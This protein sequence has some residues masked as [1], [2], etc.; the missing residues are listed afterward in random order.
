[1]WEIFIDNRLYPT[2]I[3]EFLAAATGIL[4]LLKSKALGKDDKLLVYYLIFIFV[5]D[6]LAITYGLYGYVYNWKHLDFISEQFR[7]IYWIYNILTLISTTAYTTYFYL[8]LESSFLR[9]LIAALTIVF[10]I[11][12]ILSYALG[13]QFFSTTSSYSYIAASFLIFFAVIFYYFELLKSDRLLN[14]STEL[15]LYIS[16]GLLIYQLAITP[17]FIFQNYISVSDDFR[18]LYSWI[19]DIGNIFLYTV[20]VYGFLKKISEIKKLQRQSYSRYGLKEA[21]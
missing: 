15:P 10:L 21:E 3:V 9:K 19:L 1:M 7:S 18:R 12:S 17:L 5:F 6:L 11:S 16:A 4:Y 14:F 2:Y 13:E 8:Q 20:F